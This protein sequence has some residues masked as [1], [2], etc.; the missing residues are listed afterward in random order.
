MYITARQVVVMAVAL[1]HVPYMAQ[2]AHVSQE[3]GR[4][5]TPVSSACDGRP[6]N[7]S[8]VMKTCDDF[9]AGRCAFVNTSELPTRV[10]TLTVFRETPFNVTTLGEKN[11]GDAFGDVG[12]YLSNH[13]MPFIC[14]QNPNSSECA[15]SN[16]IEKGSQ[17]N[18]FI[19]FIL[20]VDGNF[21]PYEMCNP[22]HGWDTAHW[23]CLTYCETPPDCDPWTMQK[24][25]MDWMGP[26]CFCP[27]GHSNRTVGRLAQSGNHHHSS[28]NGSNPWP[29]TCVKDNFYNITLFNKCVNGTVLKHIPGAAATPEACCSACADTLGCGGWSMFD[30]PGHGCSLIADKD[31][32]LDSLTSDE[33]CVSA[34][35]FHG[36]LGHISDGV[37][38][39]YWYSLPAAG[40]CVGTA[41]PGDATGCTWRVVDVLK[42]VNSTCVG[43][44]VD[45]AIHAYAASCFDTCPESERHDPT[46]ACYTVCYASAINGNTS[47]VPP[48]TPMEKND[49]IAPFLHA[50]GDSGGCPALHPP[51]KGLT[52]TR[53]HDT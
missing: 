16:A 50:F 11:C 48:L 13:N 23:E 32:V 25:T 46:S 28:T 2:A 38:G 14:K 53:S 1:S 17:N 19:Q 49:V 21:G 12:F 27:N 20:E 24:S 47:M 33:K 6:D 30:G 51:T 29:A 41:R 15:D 34:Y 31:H 35:D 36:G 10:H 3:V 5:A 9:C 18:V 26:T 44:R 7:E 37:L 40:E 39:G 43:Q 4:S 8:E 52:G 22:M 42:I 45:A